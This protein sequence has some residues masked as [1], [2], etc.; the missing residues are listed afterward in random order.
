MHMPDVLV[1][2]A[3]ALPGL[4]ASGALL[5]WS[6][7]KAARE[8]DDRRIPLMGVLGA[9][10]FAAQM[11]NLPLVVLPGVSWHLVGAVL[12]AA[13]LGPYAAFIVMAAI[14]TIQALLLG[15]GG[16]LALG[17]NIFNMGAVS[18]FL[19]YAV[20]SAATSWLGGARGR[21]AGIVLASAVSLTAASLAAVIQIHL[22]GKSPVSLASAAW[23]MGSVHALCGIGEGVL[24]VAVL[25]FVAKARPAS[26][27]ERSPAE[28]AAMR[29]FALAGLAVSLVIGG[30]VSYWA[31]SLPDGLEHAGEVL[32]WPFVA[33]AEESASFMSSVMTGL[34][35]TA[36]A[37]AVSLVLA[38]VMSRARQ[39][40]PERS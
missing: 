8:M 9:F 2:P 6:C 4:A 28:R 22:S 25:A 39:A 5:A 18:C 16:L 27:Q 17:C 11:I 29:K 31:S 26:V 35:T 34:L 3:V 7:R 23:L 24:S 19:G 14:L 13:M 15:D 12:M 30:F 38:A 32:R 20:Y 36:I 1:S 33:E 21:A 40:V 37:F 10:V